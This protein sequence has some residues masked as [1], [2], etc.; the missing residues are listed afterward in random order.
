MMIAFLIVLLLILLLIVDSIRSTTID[1]ELL[2]AKLID[3]DEEIDKIQ[4][5]NDID[6]SLCKE[7]IEG[8]SFECFEEEATCT[9]KNKLGCGNFGCVWKSEV[10]FKKVDD[11]IHLNDYYERKLLQRERVLRNHI[12]KGS[13]DDDNNNNSL[14]VAVKILKDKNLDLASIIVEA[15][16]WAEV[17]YHPN[18]IDLIHTEIVSCNLLFYSELVEGDDVDHTTPNL[19]QFSSEESTKKLLTISLGL[20]QGLAHVNNNNLHHFDIKPANLMVDNLLDKVKICDF[21]LAQ[22]NGSAIDIVGNIKLK[23]ISGGTPIYMSPDGKE[24]KM[25]TNSNN[26]LEHKEKYIVCCNS[27][28]Q[29]AMALSILDLWTQF[30]SN[31]TFHSYVQTLKQESSSKGIGDYIIRNYE[32]LKGEYFP[33]IPVNVLVKLAEIL[34]VDAARRPCNSRDLEHALIEEAKKLNLHVTE[35]L[36]AEPQSAVIAFILKGHQ[37][38][39]LAVS[40][41]SIDVRKKT[42]YESLKL[43]EIAQNNAVDDITIS[44]YCKEKIGIIYYLLSAVEKAEEQKFLAI[45]TSVNYFLDAADLKSRRQELYFLGVKHLSTNVIDYFTEA[46]EQY[47]KSPLLTK[48]ME[49]QFAVK[50]ANRIGPSL[51]DTQDSFISCIETSDDKSCSNFLKMYLQGLKE[52][53]NDN[54]ENSPLNIHVGSKVRIKDVDHYKPHFKA[55]ETATV[56]SIDNINKRCKVVKSSLKSAWVKC[57]DV[58]LLQ[59]GDEDKVIYHHNYDQTKHGYHVLMFFFIVVIP[60]SLLYC[61]C[62]CCFSFTR[63]LFGI[64]KEKND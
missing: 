21:G 62:S 42:L 36:P 19:S 53:D 46:L 32:T 5:I 3:V 58:L 30:S 10:V 4:K 2:D 14:Y 1:V 12:N 15:I 24:M 60:L 7:V 33:I 23:I 29:W 61:A 28:D 38:F 6:D 41:S 8:T 52:S 57:D 48:D 16:T 25:C 59:F 64:K 51:L 49:K 27:H 39:K 40:I 35:Y 37:I 17:P 56:I 13:N 45:K 20:V 9:L 43:Y 31:T 34:N 47:S 50:T 44:V 54:N 18:V 26:H 63:Y 11:M 22:S 55:N